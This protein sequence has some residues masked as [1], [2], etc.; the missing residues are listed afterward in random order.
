VQRC[1]KVDEKGEPYSFDFVVES[2][3]V[4][5]PLY[6]VGRAIEV[7]Q[8][9]LLKY[10]SIDSGD[11]PP[12]LRVLPSEARGPLFDFIFQGEDHTLGN[13]LQT[14]IDQQMIDSGEV[15]FVGY[16]VPHPLRDEMVLRV[17]VK[18]GKDI[19]ARAAV[20]KACRDCAKMFKD[21]SAM[22]ANS[23]NGI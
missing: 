11:L 4:L 8:A 5:D 22:W 15:M 19:D 12:N 10:A 13:L 17:G 3:G 16:K 20:A 1:Y 21:W 2:V 9:K 23:T 18:E 7:I 6:V 14:W